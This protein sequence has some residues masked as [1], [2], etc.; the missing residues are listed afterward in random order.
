M[1]NLKNQGSQMENHILLAW[2]RSSGNHSQNELNGHTIS[3]SI[4][5][6]FCT[7]VMVAPSVRTTK[8]R[9]SSLTLLT[10]PHFDFPSPLQQGRRRRQ[11]HSFWHYHYLE[12][13]CLAPSFGLSFAGPTS[14]ASPSRPQQLNRLSIRQSHHGW[15]ERS[16]VEARG[17]PRPQGTSS[18]CCP[19]T[20][21]PHSS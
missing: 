13:P 11:S 21:G 17:R 15:S 16:K 6:I 7:V 20:T 5:L 19:R 10:S 12:Q 8:L 4:S 2:V 3:S 9:L 14:Q 18:A 1:V